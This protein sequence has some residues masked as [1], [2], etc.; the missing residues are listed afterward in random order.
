MTVQRFLA[1]IFI[2]IT[3]H[4]KYFL[5]QNK[6]SKKSPRIEPPPSRL[7]EIPSPPVPRAAV[8]RPNQPSP[9]PALQNRYKTA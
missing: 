9:L 7:K 1:R 5:Y 3:S 6:D 8:S 2:L 4:L